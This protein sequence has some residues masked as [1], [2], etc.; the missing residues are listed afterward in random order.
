[1]T[2]KE[3]NGKG[4]Y[5]MRGLKYSMLLCLF[6]SV[7]NFAHAASIVD[8]GPG[9]ANPSNFYYSLG[10]SQFIAGKFN[11]SQA[12]DITSIFGWV[13]NPASSTETFTIA[14]YGDAM[15]GQVPDAANQIFAQQATASS[16]AIDWFGLS[17]LNLALTPGSY[18]V[19]FEVRAGDT[20][21]GMMPQP[22]ASPLADYAFWNPNNIPQWQPFDGLDSGI[23]ISGDP[24]AAVPEPATMLLLGSGLIGLAGYGRKKFFKE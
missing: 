23:R 4:E 9:P 11:L 18:W 3:G 19:S 14:V 6:L 15:G 24:Q 1:M 17:G 7:T 12:Y 8:T 20:L 21:S 22:A 16:G 13:D 2:E 10:S 5:I